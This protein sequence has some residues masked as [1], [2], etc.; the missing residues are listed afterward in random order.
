MR[1]RRWLAGPPR[2]SDRLL[3]LLA[4]LACLAVTAVP[5]LIHVEAPSL[6][7]DEPATLA[8][9]VDTWR[10]EEQLWD[11]DWPPPPLVPWSDGAAQL[12]AAP[13]TTWLHL[14][15]LRGLDRDNA[16]PGEVV[17]HARLVSVVL[18]LIVVA[19]AFWAGL[20]IGGLPTAVL[21][22]LI[23]AATP[24][25]VFHA[26]LATS[27]LPVVATS[28]L[29]VAA[30]LWALRPL[31]P[32]VAL[33]RQAAGWGL[34]GLCLGLATLTGG[35]LAVASVVVP[36]VLMLVL[37]PR[38]LGH[39]LG[40][41]A[42]AFVAALV[43]V[44]WALYVHEQ[45]AEVWRGWLA[46]LMPGHL[47]QVGPAA[48]LLGERAIFLL[49]LTL[50]WTPWLAVSLAQPFSTSSAGARV[51]L[52]IG[53]VWFVAVALLV[54][55][56]PEQGSR[57][58]LL[59]VLPAMA[60]LVGQ[61]MRQYAELSAEGRHAR[62]WQA[63]RWPFAT[64]VLAASIALPLLA[65]LQGYLIDEGVIGQ[66]WTAAVHGPYWASTAVVLLAVAAL[67][68]RYV[69]RQYPG[70]ATLAWALWVLVA[71]TTLIGPVAT[72][73]RVDGGPDAAAVV[74]SAERALGD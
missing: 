26:R 7:L 67:A 63:V 73:P 61:V 12:D 62:L 68:T 65:H 5:L 15:A 3:A 48:R 11:V 53:W 41:V 57:G 46:A 17:H 50:P 19:A 1:A 36:L 23:M 18:G 6:V 29:A 51:R 58:H 40:L 47:L 20:S 55:L 14:L 25:M 49:L 31:K 70:R 37:C 42:A 22:G 13:G 24:A 27:D 52:F 45:E 39:A 21:A 16:D 35:L 69:L 60:V 4:L 64:L 66:R 54:L 9:S 30:G 44:P 56:A 28:L 71:F 34:S 10:A 2:S 59:L 8:R 72:G 74:S 32:T 43:T 38:R 33:P